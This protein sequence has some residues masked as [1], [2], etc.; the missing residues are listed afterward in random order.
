MDVVGT[1]MD[2]LAHLYAL[3]RLASAEPDYCATLWAK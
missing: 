1:G 2:H 3:L